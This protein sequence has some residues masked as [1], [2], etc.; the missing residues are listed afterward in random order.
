MEK[1]SLNIKF[2]RN[3]LPG[4]QGRSYK[5]PRDNCRTN[6][7]VKFPNGT[8]AANCNVDDIYSVRRDR[9][10]RKPRANSDCDQKR[11]RG[12]ICGNVSKLLSH[13]NST[14]FLPIF[15]PVSCR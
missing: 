6:D 15:T 14:F 8:I 12:L 2:F 1:S 10:C 9:Q 7:E 4:R 11:I 3:L 5:I 13:Y